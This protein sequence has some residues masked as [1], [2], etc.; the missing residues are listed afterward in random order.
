MR[1]IKTVTVVG[2]N[3]T[4]GNK[5][6]ALFA[7]FGKAKV[8]MVVRDMRYKE[9]V[10]NNAIKSI[11]SDSIKDRLEV[12]DYDRLE[13][14]VKDSDLVFE[15]V[16]ET[17]EIKKKI[18]KRIDA[19]LS[20]GT[21]LSTGTSGLSIDELSLM[22]SESNRKNFMGI[23]FF[24]PPY[25]L[26]FCEV[27]LNKEHNLEDLNEVVSYLEKVLY[28]D[29]I[30]VKNAPAFLGNRIG[31]QFINQALKLAD[32]NKDRGGIDYIDSIFDSNTGRSMGP[33]HTANY[34]GIDIHKNIVDYIYSETQDTQTADFRLPNFVNKLIEKGN[35]GSKTGKGLYCYGGYVYDI[36]S[37]T[38]REPV[39]YDFDFKNKMKLLISQ[40]DYIDAI[41]R[42]LHDKS[43]EANLC[44]KLI[45]ENYI[46]ALVLSCKIC[47]D[48]SA[49]DSAMASGFNWCPPL[50]FMELVKEVENWKEILIDSINPELYNETTKFFELENLPSSNYDYRKFYRY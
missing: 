48:I 24:N 17:M 19:V 1:E 39:E 25:Q 34:V 29:V 20:E 32:S 36:V 9:T 21:I 14:C 16:A 10:L 5:V 11:Q 49:A 4:M 38:Y 46:Y 22:I 44:R 15:S 7:S 41:T 12:V 6:G 45:F 26:P 43:Y 50:A 33:I 23:H 37:D 18:L 40:G 8:Y 2:A 30:T 47:D 13:E 35:L 42:L 31:F 27:I 3:G 28:R